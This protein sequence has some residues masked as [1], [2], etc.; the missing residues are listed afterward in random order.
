MRSFIAAEENQ[1]IPSMTIKGEGLCDFIINSLNEMRKR[2][3]GMAVAE[4]RKMEKAVKRSTAD[5]V[6]EIQR[7]SSSPVEMMKAAEALTSAAHDSI[8]MG[9]IKTLLFPELY[10]A[11]IP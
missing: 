3:R 4:E 7:S 1:K 8:D 11:D 6:R 2:Q 9:Y 10:N 5:I